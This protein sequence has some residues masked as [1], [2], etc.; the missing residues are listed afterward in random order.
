MAAGIRI[1]LDLPHARQLLSIVRRRVA[2]LDDYI[3]RESEKLDAVEYLLT[4]DVRGM[5]ANCLATIE[6]AMPAEES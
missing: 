3:A 5:A 4:R 2:E 1:E 6:Q